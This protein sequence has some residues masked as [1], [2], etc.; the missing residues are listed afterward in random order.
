MIRRSPAFLATAAAALAFTTAACVDDA[1]TD[2][3]TVAAALEQENGGLDMEDEAP[4]FGADDELAAAS[5]EASNAFTDDMA[6][7]GETLALEA[8]PGAVVANLVLLWGQLPPDL[9][10][11]DYARDWSGTLRVDRGAIVVRRTIAFEN[12]TDRVLPRTD[13]TA[14]EFTSVTRPFN[15]GLVLTVIDPDPAAGPMTLTY[16]LA[17]G[18]SHSLVLSELLDG[19]VVVEVDDQGD[20]IAAIAI[21]NRDAC[22]HGFVRGR[23]R[24]LRQGLG[25]MIGVVHDAD[26][27]PNGHIRGIWGERRNGEQVFFGKYIA[28]DGTFRGLFAGHYADGDFRGRW[29]TR[30][31]DHGRVQ[32]MYRESLPGR[33]AGGQFIGRWAETSCAA[34]LP[35]DN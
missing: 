6:A 1:A 34:D 5:I 2:A 19:P 31:G 7:D 27:T 8:A 25:G 35:A 30:G 11:E 14:V 13:R 22:D 29:L 9:A 16:E 3:D 24:A 28:E 18:T 15:D 32:G 4:I 33:P 23:W 12:A 26:G 21:R 20:R 17:D 10:P